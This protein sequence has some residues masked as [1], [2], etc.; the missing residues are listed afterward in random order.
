MYDFFTIL[1]L[2]VVFFGAAFGIAYGF[3]I[4]ADWFQSRHQDDVDWGEVV[5]RMYDGVHNCRQCGGHILPENSYEGICDDCW[6]I[7]RCDVCDVM[8]EALPGG[9]WCGEC[10]CCVDHCQEYVSCQKAR[11][12]EW[13]ALMRVVEDEALD[14]EDHR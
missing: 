3:M 14:T 13:Q 5:R 9:E 4:V 10:G 2:L 12:A 8:A 11:N 1:A 7:P 6:S